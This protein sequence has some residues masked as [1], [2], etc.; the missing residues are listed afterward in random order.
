MITDRREHNDQ[1]KERGGLSPYSIL[2]VAAKVPD[3]LLKIDRQVHRLLVNREMLVAS[4]GTPKKFVEKNWASR[5]QSP[6]HPSE[7]IKSP[8]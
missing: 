8:K 4:H 6:L 5:G 7:I 3:D 2:M 1:A